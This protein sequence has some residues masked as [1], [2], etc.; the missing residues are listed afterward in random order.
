MLRYRPA[1]PGQHLLGPVAQVIDQRGL[2]VAQLANNGAGA[3]A[4]G[5]FAGAFAERAPA[6]RTVIDVALGKPRHVQPG[7]HGVAGKQDRLHGEADAE[8]E[9][10]PFPGVAANEDGDHHDHAGNKRRC[11]P[12]R[13]RAGDEP[14]AADQHERRDCEGK[15]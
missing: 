14:Q 5:E 3:G 12:V 4:A 9:R 6:E 7:G 11:R 1:R 2:V 10:E 8:A 13:E 15:H